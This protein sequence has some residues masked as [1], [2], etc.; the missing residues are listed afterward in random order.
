MD[1]DGFP[2]RMA[3]SGTIVDAGSL[4]ICRFDDAPPVSRWLR[5]RLSDT[6][7]TYPGEQIVVAVQCHEDKKELLTGRRV[8]MEVWKSII[9]RH[10]PHGDR[11]RAELWARRCTRA[12][13]ATCAWAAERSLWRTPREAQPGYGRGL[14][15]FRPLA[16]EARTA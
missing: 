8:R 2:D 16:P 12:T 5:I 4:R 9:G 7:A 13:P 1:G 11:R 3:V 6:T 15:L 14:A 10:H